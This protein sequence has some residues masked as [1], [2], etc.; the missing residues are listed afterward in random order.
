MWRRAA[1]SKMAPSIFTCE[2]T[3]PLRLLRR[4][5]PCQDWDV[6]LAEERP[7]PPSPAEPP[8]TLPEPGGRGG[9][10]G[11]SHQALITEPEWA[12]S[13]RRKRQDDGFQTAAPERDVT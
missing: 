2:S 7:P 11:G 10:S 5:F 8:Q 12:Q 3:P 6:V 9:S 4:P 1:A 13:C